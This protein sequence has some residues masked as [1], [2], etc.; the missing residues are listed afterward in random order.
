MNL[1]T[2]GPRGCAIAAAIKWDLTETGR[3]VG[4]ASGD[5][6]GD[7]AAIVDAAACAPKVAGHVPAQ[8]V[9]GGLVALG[10]P[11]GEPQEVHGATL[12]KG[13]ECLAGACVQMARNGESLG[14]E[15]EA[16][17]QTLSQ[18]CKEVAA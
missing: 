13:P 12:S 9:I 4:R 16:T 17:V 18:G 7:R 3:Q 2:L 5:V 14:I 10:A 6:L 8:R 1:S 11:S 15:H